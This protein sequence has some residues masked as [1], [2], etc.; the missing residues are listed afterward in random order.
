[1]F[2][3]MQSAVLHK[4]S[5]QNPFW[6]FNVDLLDRYVLK[7]LVGPFAMCVAGFLVVALSGELFGLTSLIIEKRVPVRQVVILLMYRLPELLV[8]AI[9]VGVLFAVLME[10][11]RMARDAELIVIQISGRSLARISAPLAVLGIVVGILTFG[12]NEYVVPEANHRSQQII[13]QYVLRGVMQPAKQ[14]VFF[15]GTGNRYYYLGYVNRSTMQVQDILV[16]EL[17]GS[18]P[19][20]VIY[21]SSGTMGPIAWELRD[22]VVQEMDSEGITVSQ[23]RFDRMSYVV[24]DQLGTFVGEQKTTME[25]SRSEIREIIEMYKSSGIDLRSFRVDYEFKLAL[26]FA[27]AVFAVL[28]AGCCVGARKNG[29]FYSIAVSVGL[30]FA[31]YVV[32]AV[33]RSLGNE[34]VISPPVAAWSANALFLAVGAGLIMRGDRII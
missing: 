5:R 25:M 16:F 10:L 33:L 20:R 13:R 24:E 15:R 7:G 4:E 27:A 29:R 8:T 11:G 9:P 22:G 30:A 1:M 3:K 19:G 17:Q 28:G 2:A 21:A 18:K 32:S 12:L 14:E 26:P 23:T 34:G 6:T 31:Y